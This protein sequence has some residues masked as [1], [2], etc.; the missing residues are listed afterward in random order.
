[1]TCV[2]PRGCHS[3][4]CSVVVDVDSG[5]NEIV[6]PRRELRLGCSQEIFRSGVARLHLRHVIEQAKLSQVMHCFPFIR[7]RVHHY[8][9]VFC[10]ATNSELSYMSSYSHTILQSFW[11]IQS[12]LSDPIR[13]TVTRC[14][15]KPSQ[16]QPFNARPFSDQGCDGNQIQIPGASG[17]AR[18]VCFLF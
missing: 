5:D 17:V 4:K 9:R 2:N 6:V 7:M 11:R 3:C 12:D 10:S 13:L 14:P 18:Q 16:A 1:M 15:A 8:R